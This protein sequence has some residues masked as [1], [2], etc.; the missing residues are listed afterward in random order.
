[1]TSSK[2]EL[3]SLSIDQ[4]W[5]FHEEVGT[6]LSQRILAEKRGL[7]ERLARLNRGEKAK[8]VPSHVRKPH[9]RKP[10]RRKYPAVAPKFQNPA[11]PSETWAGRGKQPRWLVAQLKAGKKL[12]DFLIAGAKRQSDKRRA[13]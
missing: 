7:E 12:N 8:I 2:L 6:L 11:E 10:H 5:A 1:M 13:A 4:L 9:R 3:K